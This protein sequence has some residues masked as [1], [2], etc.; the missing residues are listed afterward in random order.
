MLK[1][2]PVRA[3]SKERLSS[4]SSPSPWLL[5]ATAA[6]LFSVMNFVAHRSSASTHWT[7]VAATRAVVG[8]IVGIGVAR[9][10]GRP[11][12]VR[13]SPIMWL[14]SVL[15]TVA[16]GCTFFALGRREL[17]LG[18]ATTLLNLTPLILALLAPLVLRERSGRGVWGPLALSA[19]GVL[20][21]VRPSF[22]FGGADSIPTAAAI[23][24]MVA[25]VGSTFS[26][27]AMMSL[28]RA[29]KGDVAEAIVVHFSLFGAV[30]LGG[31]ALVLN[32]PPPPPAQ[33][34]W[35]LVAGACGGLAQVAMT[36][37]YARAPAAR[38]SGVGYLAVPFSAV[39]GAIALGE[40]PTRWTVVGMVL[41]VAG[42]LLLA[43]AG[44][45]PADSARPETK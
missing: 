13:P 37:A 27:F 11:A 8:A 32:A 26:A 4:S 29:S 21:I 15:G 40:V 14:R 31:A 19:A 2:S 42:G 38:L 7:W 18:D 1:A 9:V 16:M 44:A 23:P 43:R 25:L 6:A 24:A 28:R 10:R 12:F 17:P 3:R 30:T 22:L 36:T 41:V 45:A 34:P 35:L 5:M 39:L 33:L 20:L